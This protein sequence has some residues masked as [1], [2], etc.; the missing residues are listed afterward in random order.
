MAVEL[1]GMDTSS[2]AVVGGR[3]ELDGVQYVIRRAWNEREASWVVSLYTED[4]APIVVGAFARTGVDL[5]DNCAAAG[6]PPG[7]LILEDVSGAGAELTFD[8]WGRTH[9]L[10]YRE[11]RTTEEA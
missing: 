11:P 2:D 9:R 10:V 7:R 6:R 4:L 3:W 1:L 5:L 8:G